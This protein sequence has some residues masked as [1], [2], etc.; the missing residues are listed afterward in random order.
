[1]SA[2]LPN[3]PIVVGTI[4]SHAAL[5]EALRLKPWAVDLLELRVDYFVAD[6]DSL[7]R[8]VPKLRAPLIVTV[9]HPREGGACEL[10]NIERVRLFAEFLPCASF[11]DVE[12]R[13]IAVLEATLAAARA[14]KTGIIVSDHHFK[15]TPSLAQLQARRQMA[16]QAQP[17]IFKVATFTSRPGEFA[18]LLSF[19]TATKNPP[20]LSV[21][22][23]G[24]FGKVSR[25]ALARAGSVLNYGYLGEAQL[26]GQWPAVELK[27]RLQELA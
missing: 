22:G 25:L 13:S 10:K 17:D 2:L 26:P 3:S 16:R 20:A 21:M 23:M 8:A 7:R 9:R 1:M 18:T 14:Q 15:T 4:H 24:E 5:R 11:I 12:L 19:L 6:L 27:R